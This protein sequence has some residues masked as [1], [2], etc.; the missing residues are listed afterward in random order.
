[1]NQFCYS[2]GTDLSIIHYNNLIIAFQT[3]EATGVLLGDYCN[4]QIGIL[5]SLRDEYI[6][7]K[8]DK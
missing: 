4:M 2:E 1:M 3:L 7:L 5:E 8:K 6:E